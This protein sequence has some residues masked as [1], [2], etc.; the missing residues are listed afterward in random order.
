MRTCCLI[1]VL[2][3]AA[4]ARPDWIET[5]PDIAAR[6][7]AEPEAFRA[8]AHRQWEGLRGMVGSYRVRV[9][10][11]VGSRTFDTQ[12]FLLRDR[13]LEID[14]LS[15]AATT[16]GYL[17]AGRREIGFWAAEEGRLYRGPIEPGAFGRALGIDLG[18]D[19][20]VA[21]LMGFGVAWTGG[22]SPRAEWDEGERRIRV[23]D[24][25]GATAWLHP[26]LARFERIRFATSQGDI[27]VTVEEWADGPAPVPTRLAIRVPDDDISVEMRL[28]PRWQANPDGLNAEFFD[29]QPVEGTV[30][31]PLELLALEGGLLRRGLER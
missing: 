26:V 22:R 21:V 10:R 8:D 31:V 12:I 18:P 24:G 6:A 25:A 15:P 1:L 2:F 4:C 29:V 14:L 3:V 20:V 23:S 9:S 19:D 7:R 30:E 13:F 28:A 16:E 5:Y 27:E 17:V 11:G